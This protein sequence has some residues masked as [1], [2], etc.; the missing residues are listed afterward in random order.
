LSEWGRDR[1]RTEEEGGAAG[2]GHK[3]G[4]AEELGGA[5]E[6][7]GADLQ[8]VPLPRPGGQAPRGRGDEPLVRTVG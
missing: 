3:E 2:G 7:D 8:E 6:D 4:A 1:G 5:P